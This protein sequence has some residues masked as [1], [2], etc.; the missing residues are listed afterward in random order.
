MWGALAL[1]W[2]AISLQN[3]PLLCCCVVPSCRNA[4]TAAGSPRAAATGAVEGEV[5]ALQVEVHSLLAQVAALKGEAAGGRREGG[6]YLSGML[7]EWQAMP[8]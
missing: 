5:A 1:L 8:Q 2:H 3:S 4:A 6:C 7:G